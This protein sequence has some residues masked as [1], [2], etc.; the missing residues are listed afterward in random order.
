MWKTRALELNNQEF[1]NWDKACELVQWAVRHDFNTVVVGQVDLFDKLVSP[2]G[3]TPHQY[4]DRLSSQQRARCVYLN[5][6]AGDCQKNGLKFYLQAKELSFPADLLAAH[7]QLIDKDGS[8]R[9]DVEF[10]CQYLADKLTL[11]C[12]QIPAMSGLLVALSNTDGLL[13]ISRPNWELTGQDDPSPHIDPR[14]LSRYSQC[15]S[16][17]ARAVMR[18]NKHLVLRAFPAG[19]HDISNVMEAIRTLPSCVSVS[20]KLTPERFWPTFPNNPAL[21][22]VEDRDVWVELDLVG[23]EVG[24]GVLPFPRIDELQGRLLWCRGN[25][26]ITGA[27]CKTSWEGVDNH[28]VMGTLS[29][30][31]L[32]A[33]SQI[34]AR[35]NEHLTHAALLTHWLDESYG[36]RP[37][38]V[39]FGEFQQLLAQ[40]GQVL[41]Q[42]IYVRDHVFHRHSQVPESYGQAVWSLYGQLNRNHWLPGSERDI[43]FSASDVG[44]SGR[45]LSLIAEEKDRAY[46]A[47]Q[48]LREQALAFADRAAF[49][50]SLHRRWL[51]E[52]QGFDLYCL[53]FRHAQKAFFTLHFARLVENSWSMREIC[54]VNIQELYRCASEMDSFCAQHAEASPGLHV[55]FDPTRVRMLADSLSHELTLLKG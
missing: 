12:Q 33:C 4:N 22:D 52:W 55:L 50:F 28:W 30:C 15:F 21:V 24:W 54:Q 27:V 16:A 51:E 14:S 38:E 1:W 11:L 8:I 20:I 42:A 49:P 25:A 23:E 17:M 9:F 6:L 48:T 44:I 2:K 10:W 13:P 53:L 32:V 26:A 31:N 3:Y 18:E 45:N 43:F 37:D 29:E 41:Y 34:L 46:Q 5:R 47:A 40:A 36:W 19:N 39:I 35:E 7:P